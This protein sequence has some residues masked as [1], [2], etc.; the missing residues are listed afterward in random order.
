[1]LSIIHLP[2]VTSAMVSY[3]KRGGEVFLQDQVEKPYILEVGRYACVI[4]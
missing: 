2:I 4:M 3:L 1:M